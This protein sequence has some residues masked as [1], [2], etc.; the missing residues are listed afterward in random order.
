ML[1]SLGNN[2]FL[3]EWLRWAFSDF[4]SKYFQ[5]FPNI[6]SNLFQVTVNKTRKFQ[7]FCGFAWKVALLY[8]S[9]VIQ[10]PEK[11]YLQPVAGYG[12]QKR[13]LKFCYMFWVFLWH[14]FYEIETD[15]NRMGVRVHL[16]NQQINYSSIINAP[17]RFLIYLMI[18]ILSVA[19]IYILFLERIKNIQS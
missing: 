10:S 11:Q 12:I 7:P 13:T 3:L 5:I 1:K 14:Y 15:Q 17:P 16:N 2:F 19:K 18:I 8:E 6:P 9:G 4:I